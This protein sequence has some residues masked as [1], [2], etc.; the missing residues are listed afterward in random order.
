[1]PLKRKTPLRARTRLQPK[2]KLTA[3]KRPKKQ[4]KPKVT[5]LRK[6][7][8]LW[9]GLYVLVRDGR[10]VDD[11][12]VAPCITCGGTYPFISGGRLNKQA[13][14]WGHFQSTRFNATKFHEQNVHAQCAGCNVFRNGEQFRYARAIDV[15]YGD[16]TAERLEELAHQPHPFSHQELTDIIRQSKAFVLSHIDITLPKEYSKS[17]LS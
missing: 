8:E 4:P 3:N 10:P 14:Q 2:T 15:R 1:M 9:F 13:I 7:A 6:E 5:I 12:W 16:G 17:A 11:G